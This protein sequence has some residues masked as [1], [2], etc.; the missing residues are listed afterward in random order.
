[1]DW[2]DDQGQAA[3][4]AAVGHAVPHPQLVA[5]QET[6][7]KTAQ[8]EERAIGW[9]VQRQFAIQTGRAAS[10]GPGPSESSGGVALAVQQHI[11]STSVA[12]EEPLQ[13]FGHRVVIRK[14]NVGFPGGLLV[15][16][17]YLDV[18]EG[19][20]GPGNWKLLKSPARF[21]LIQDIPWLIQGDWN[22]SPADLIESGWLNTAVGVVFQPS[23]P[24]CVTRHKEVQEDGKEVWVTVKS[25]ID[26]FVGAKVLRHCIHKVVALDGAIASPH[27]PVVAVFRILLGAASFTKPK[28]FKM[29]PVLPIIGPHLEPERADWRH[30]PG[31]PIL[32]IPGAMR[33]WFNN[34]EAWLGVFFTMFQTSSVGPTWGVDWVLRRPW[35]LFRPC[36]TVRLVGDTVL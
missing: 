28:K 4:E 33:E 12:L 8:A 13:Q 27:V 21:L 22:C 16:S 36:G 10:T 24:T 9:G 6:R 3:L 29:F 17:L 19:P 30:G 14:I 11:A 23:C 32:D 26:F 18:K 7:M 1:M 5:V 35:C 34:S 2:Y 15:V 20:T 31:E 25:E